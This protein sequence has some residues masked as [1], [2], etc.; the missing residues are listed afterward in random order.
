[1]RERIDGKRRLRSGIAQGRRG[2]G[3]IVFAEAGEVI[4]LMDR[5]KTCY[6]P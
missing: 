6:R 4:G 2:R 1:M 5:E 3:Q